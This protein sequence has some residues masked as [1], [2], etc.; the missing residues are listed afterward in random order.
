LVLQ[1]VILIDLVVE[2]ILLLPILYS[3]HLRLLCFLPLTKK[4]CLLDFLSLVVPLLSHIGNLVGVFCLHHHVHSLFI[5]FHL[6]ALFIPHLQI[7]DLLRTFLRLLDL[8]PRL[9]LFLF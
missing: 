4:Y 8:L 3:L 7:H 5:L 1:I 6:H 2:L 9:H